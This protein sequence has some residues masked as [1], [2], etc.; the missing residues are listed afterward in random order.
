MRI[1]R[2]PAAIMP[3]NKGTRTLVYQVS[4]STF[5]D[6]RK[7]SKFMSVHAVY[8]SKGPTK[9]RVEIFFMSTR[10]VYCRTGA[11]ERG[12]CELISTRRARDASVTDPKKSLRM[13]I[14][15]SKYSSRRM[16]IGRPTMSLADMG[17][18]QSRCGMEGGSLG[19]SFR[20]H[21]REDLRAVKAKELVNLCL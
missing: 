7:S 14:W 20:C 15:P 19:S 12:S 1:G 17:R 6:R 11:A 4:N 18:Q 3:G 9:F 10:R 8:W 21:N 13:S 16:S 5:Y 2:I